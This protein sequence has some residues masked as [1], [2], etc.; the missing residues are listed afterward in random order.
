MTAE[1][2]G[3]LSKIE[4]IQILDTHIDCDLLKSLGGAQHILE[5]IPQNNN[6]SHPDDHFLVE[7]YKKTEV[8]Y[9]KIDP[10]NPTEISISKNFVIFIFKRRYESYHYLDHS[11]REPSTAT[12]FLFG[13]KLGNWVFSPFLSETYRSA[14]KFWTPPLDRPYMKSVGDDFI[15]L[16]N[17]PTM[18]FCSRIRCTE[19][20]EH[21]ELYMNGFQLEKPDEEESAKI[22]EFETLLDSFLI[23]N[24]NAS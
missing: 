8:N 14:G 24:K 5:T 3:P 9:E 7:W 4:Q 1:V 23:E 11:V 2:S 16:V 6:F 22:G 19:S 10:Q 15:E 12:L 13:N 20:D 21:L 18:I 17:E